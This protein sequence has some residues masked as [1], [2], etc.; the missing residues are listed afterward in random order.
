MEIDEDTGEIEFLGY[1]TNWSGYSIPGDVVDIPLKNVYDEEEEYIENLDGYKF[2]QWSCLPLGNVYYQS[3]THAGVMRDDGWLDVANSIPEIINAMHRN[4]V[5]LKY[6]IKIPITAWRFWY[7][8]WD[9]LT[10]EQKRKKRKAKL[11]EYNKFLVGKE[12]TAKSIMSTFA[13]SEITGKPIPGFSVEAIDDKLKTGSYIPDSN[14][15]DIQVLMGM[16]VDPEELGAKQDGGLGAGS[17]AKNREVRNN[18][19]S[20]S[21]MVEDVIF[22]PLYTVARINGWNPDIKFCFGKMLATTLD[23]NPKGI[24]SV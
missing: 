10:D 1:S 9:E 3:A 8:N 22:E 4:Q 12:H 6:I 5:S 19:I 24:E 11:D 21:A 2:A 17:G 7:S 20:V 14:A 23:K 13:V 16:G 18:A 15:A